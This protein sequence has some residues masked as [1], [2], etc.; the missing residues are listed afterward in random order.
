MARIPIGVRLAK[1]KQ[2]EALSTVLLCSQRTQTL[3]VLLSLIIDW[4][5]Q[6]EP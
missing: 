5:L 6:K 1:P 4:V 3:E 2:M